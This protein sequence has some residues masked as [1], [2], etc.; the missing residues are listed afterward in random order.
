M[1]WVVECLSAQH[2]QTLTCSTNRRAVEV[3][4]CRGGI[5]QVK[6]RE[7]GAQAHP[8]ARSKFR[9]GMSHCLTLLEEI[10]TVFCKGGNGLWYLINSRGKMILTMAAEMAQ[11]LKAQ[12]ILTKNKSLV[13]SI[14]Q[15]HDHSLT[16]F[17]RSNSFF[18]TP[19]AWCK[20]D[21]Q[22]HRDEFL[23]I[24]LNL[25]K[26]KLILLGSCLAL[27][28]PQHTSSQRMGVRVQSFPL[29]WGWWKPV[30]SAT[31][32]TETRRWKFKASLS[33][34]SSRLAATTPWYLVS[35]NKDTGNVTHWGSAHLTPKT[36]GVW[37]LML[38][39]QIFFLMVEK[40]YSVSLIFY[41]RCTWQN[42]WCY[43]NTASKIHRYT[44]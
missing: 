26:A 4:A 42:G 1:A 14:L 3:N 10:L 23:S 11:H 7:G 13:L 20:T 39:K 21:K 29:W 31:Q 2:V 27:N 19:W 25:W 33:T 37:S 28:G 36:M 8:Q 32:E 24:Y 18:W 6:G 12:A 34:V 22:A 35:K 15:A 30:T 5:E 38:Q 43:Q 41:P 17:R 44:K 16:H 40:R 9:A